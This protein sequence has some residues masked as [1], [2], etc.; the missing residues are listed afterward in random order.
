MERNFL[1]ETDIKKEQKSA[2][3]VNECYNELDQLYKNASQILSNLRETQKHD[4]KELASQ[5]VSLYN[6]SVAELS[7]RQKLE[8]EIKSKKGRKDQL[9]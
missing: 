3:T 2:N 9:A 4:G 6:R 5:I 1:R 7:K 8:K